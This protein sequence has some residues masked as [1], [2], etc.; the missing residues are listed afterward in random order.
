[1]RLGLRLHAVLLQLMLVRRLWLGLLPTVARWVL[2]LWLGLRL[3][4]WL[5]LRMWLVDRLFELRD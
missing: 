2:W 5:R 3:R 1:M 4:L